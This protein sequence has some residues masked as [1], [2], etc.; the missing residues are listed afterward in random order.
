MPDIID[1]LLA[2]NERF[3]H[4]GHRESRELY[5]ELDE[6]GQSPSTLVVSCC[7]SRVSPSQVFDAAPG[8]LFVVRN[9]GGFIPPYEADGGHHGTSAAVEFA[10]EV[11]GV[12][13]VVALSHSRCAGIAYGSSPKPDGFRLRHPHLSRWLDAMNLPVEP[14]GMADIEQRAAHQ[15]IRN[16]AGYPCVTTSLAKRSLAIAAM[17]FDI[18]SG[19]LRIVG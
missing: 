15:S 16:L 8:S 3:R 4:I 7:D 2:G 9:I 1:T 14:T 18:R 17:H 11:I 10:V 19:A 12:K 13:A 6:H 5:E